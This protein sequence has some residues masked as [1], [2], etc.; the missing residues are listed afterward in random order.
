MNESPH[1]TIAIVNWNGKSLLRTCLETL[2][3]YTEYSSYTVVVV[4]NGST[5]GSVQMLSEEFPHVDIIENSTNRGFAT[6][7]NQVFEQFPK[8]DYYLL[9]NNDIEITSSGWLQRFVDVAERT[10]A[11]I[12]GC[13]LIYPDGSLQHG[14]GIIKPSPR[15]GKNINEC[16]KEILEQDGSKEWNPDYVTGASL[17]VRKRV[18]SD[19]GGF[20]EDYSP[21]FYEETDLCVRARGMGHKIVYT[22]DIHLIH[23]EGKSIDSVPDFFFRNQ[24]YFI[25]THFSLWWLILQMPYELRNLVGHIYHNRSLKTIYYPV[26]KNMLTILAKRWR[27]GIY[28]E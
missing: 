25:L 13:R 9:L 10:G 28:D 26:I 2:S 17:L 27:V 22:P 15:P 12:T 7:N 8:T 14:G 18:I 5:D 11:G 4:D 3:T 24:I 6:A 19:T 16:N 21:A 20:D 1:V 23:K